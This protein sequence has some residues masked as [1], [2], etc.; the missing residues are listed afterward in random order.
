MLSRTLSRYGLAALIVAALSPAATPAGDDRSDGHE[1]AHHAQDH[2]HDNNGNGVRD[3]RIDR[4]DVDLDGGQISIHGRHFRPGRL[5]VKLAGEELVVDSATR[6]L[7]VAWLPPG[8]TP[9]DYRLLVATGRHDARR[10]VFFDVTAGAAGTQGEPGPAG[11][12]GPVGMTGPA[13]PAGAAGPAG[14][15]GPPGPQGAQGATGMTGPAGTPGQTGPQGPAGP[16]GTTPPQ[17]LMCVTRS[18]PVPAGRAGN[19]V[20]IVTVPCVNGE[21]VTGGGFDMSDNNDSFNWNRALSR[22]SGNAWQCA[23]SVSLGVVP[24]D[25]CYARCCVLQ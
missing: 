9:G 2:D 23:R 7:I 24:T 11:P 16:P 3:P 20:T 21:V 18:A 5:T 1:H 13:G 8:M 22:P 14:P 12:P 15:P 25:I 4:V 19:L 10:K 17:R 6:K